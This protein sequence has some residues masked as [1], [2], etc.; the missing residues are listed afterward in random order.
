MIP[1]P[2]ARPPAAAPD[3]ALRAL[4]VAALV[5]IGVHLAC[6]ALLS[7]SGSFF[8]SEDDPYRAYLAYLVRFRDAPGLIGR[9]WLPLGGLLQAAAQALGV[10]PALAGPAVGTLA[11]AVVVA[12][13]ASLAGGWA[14]AAQRRHAWWAGVLIGAASP[15]TIRLAQSSLADLTGAAF[16]AL[17]V[18]G[19][20]RSARTGR[21]AP[22]A[23]GAAALLAGTWT[24]YECW[25]VALAYP[26]LALWLHGRGDAPRRRLLACAAVAAVPILGPVGWMVA[27]RAVLGD[28]FAF[29]RA[30]REMSKA[31]AGDVSRSGI[32]LARLRALVLWAPAVLAWTAL[33]LAGRGRAALANAGWGAGLMALATLPP[34]L[35]GREQVVFTDRFAYLLELGL[36]PVAA[37]ALGRVVAER[38]VR[39]TVL[40]AAAGITVLCAGL[41]VVR[42]AALWD[43]D[44]V[45]LG[46]ALRRGVLDDR[47]GGGALLIERPVPRPPFG[48]ASVGVLWGRWP[49]TV[50]GTARADGWQL[51]EPSDVVRSRAVVAP[52]ALPAWL[53]ARGVRAAW[54][55]T[56]PGQR[57]VRAAWPDARIEPRGRGVLLW[58]APTDGALR[59]RK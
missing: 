4:A 59:S 2:R 9:F 8:A 26:L 21:L 15:M 55:L 23:G 41:A 27:Q 16:L 10:P 20:A 51:V 30:A 25:P 53:D 40:A 37:L 36:W 33:G 58:R 42:P 50:F 44:S 22:L 3:A 34:L 31:L 43:R 52:P 19:L 24:R 29:Y 35:T 1:A 39:P 57:A 13:L 47:L 14:P 5:A 48:W 32:A 46:L 38:P 6:R 7:A 56:G 17:A 18:A 28:P 49:R 45:E 12:A 11:A 54:M